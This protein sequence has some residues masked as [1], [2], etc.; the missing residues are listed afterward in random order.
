MRPGPT[1][2]PN[3]TRMRPDLCHKSA[4]PSRPRS[5]TATAA[6][7]NRGGSRASAR[8]ARTARPPTRGHTWRHTETSST[9]L[10]TRSSCIVFWRIKTR[11]PPIGGSSSDL[12]PDVSE[13]LTLSPLCLDQDQSKSR[14]PG[15]L[16]TTTVRYITAP[17]RI[18]VWAFRNYK[19]WSV[20]QGM[21]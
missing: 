18:L 5:G 13:S 21:L 14:P 9:V 20:E 7:R 19:A 3:E 11:R 2:T 1:E 17:G 12:D 4:P 6:D 15:S 16:W 10:S 8:S